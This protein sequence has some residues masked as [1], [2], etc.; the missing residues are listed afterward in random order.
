MVSNFIADGFEIL[1]RAVKSWFNGKTEI[2]EVMLAALNA[3]YETVQARAIETI[4]YFEDIARGTIFRFS[5]DILL[6]MYDAMQEKIKDTK[7]MNREIDIQIESIRSQLAFAE[8]SCVRMQNEIHALNHEL[9]VGSDLQSFE[10]I[11][12]P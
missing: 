12:A 6:S 9:R 4:K 11:I 7:N 5:P 10:T 2:T 1:D 8:A 3:L